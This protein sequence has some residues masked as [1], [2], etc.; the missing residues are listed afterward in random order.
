[1]KTAGTKSCVK[2]CVAKSACNCSTDLPERSARHASLVRDTDPANYSK[3][4]EFNSPTMKPKLEKKMESKMDHFGIGS[5]LAGAARIYFQSAKRT[6]KTTSLV[7]SL[8][9]GDRVVFTNKREAH[10]VQTL[11]RERGVSIK[12]IVSSTD[13]PDRLLMHGTSSGDARTVFDHSWVEA[14]FNTAIERAIKD[15][16]FF[17]TSLSGTGKPHRDTRRQFEELSKWGV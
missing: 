1:M 15:V 5:G 10:R 3:A 13:T 4:I 16:D 9:D 17:E 2:N 7:D 14:Y 6:G 12:V 8:K 11:C